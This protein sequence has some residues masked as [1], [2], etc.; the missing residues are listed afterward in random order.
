MFFLPLPLH[1][2]YNSK[3]GKFRWLGTKDRM[4]A[5]LVPK[6][7]IPIEF[8]QISGLRGKGIKSLLLAP[9]AILRAVCQ[10][11]KIIQQYQPNAVLGMGGYVSGP[12]G[13]AAKLCGVPVILHEQNAVAGLTNEWL[14]K[15]ATRVLQAFPT[16]FKDAEV[17]GN[18]VRQDL[19][20]MPS[21]QARFSERSGKI[22]SA[23]RGGKPKGLAVTQSN[24][25]TSG[26]DV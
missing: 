12:G 7:G 10:A 18:P 19:F 21:P 8:I 5:Q 9:F 22:E 11:R 13:I 3:V 16:A 15:I 17:V 24:D 20:E 2:N 4:E 1:K 23:R 26:C 14:A 25:S 6:H